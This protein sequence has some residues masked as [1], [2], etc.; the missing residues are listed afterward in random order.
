[1]KKKSPGEG[2]LMIKLEKIYMFFLWGWWSVWT[3]SLREPW[4]LRWQV[5][6]EGE[7]SGSHGSQE[8]K[9]WKPMDLG[10]E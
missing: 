6:A 8:T 10:L 9:S 5:G 7:L 3:L 2:G 4:T 1:M